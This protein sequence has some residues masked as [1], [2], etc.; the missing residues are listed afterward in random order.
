MKLLVALAQ[1]ESLILTKDELIAKA[2]GNRPVSDEAITRA[3]SDLRRILGDSPDDPRYIKTIPRLGYRLL[4]KPIFVQAKH[5]RSGFSLRLV[6]AVLLITMGMWYLLNGDAPVLGELEFSSEAFEVSLPHVREFDFSSDGNYMAYITLTGGNQVLRVK[7]IYTRSSYTLFSHAGE[8]RAPRF[9]PADGFLAVLATQPRCEIHVLDLESIQSIRVIPCNDAYAA[10]PDWQTEQTLVFTDRTAEGGWDVIQ[11]EP[12]AA[13]V[14]L[15]LPNS[16]CVQI[17]QL[18]YLNDDRISFVCDMRR[19]QSLQRWPIGSAD[20]DTL[21]TLRDIGF[22]DWLSIDEVLVAHRSPWKP[23]LTYLNVDTGYKAYGEDHRIDRFGVTGP[24]SVQTLRIADRFNTWS[25]SQTGN[26]FPRPVSIVD[27]SIRSVSASSDGLLFIS[28]RDEISNVWLQEENGKAVPLIQNLDK[29]AVAIHSSE[30]G[31]HVAVTFALADDGQ[32]STIYSLQ[33]QD[34]VP[35][36]YL[37]SASAPVRFAG[38]FSVFVPASADQQNGWY[39]LNIDSGDSRLVTAKACTD[40]QQ[41]PRSETLYCALQGDSNDRLVALAADDSEAELIPHMC[42]SSWVV[43]S[44][45]IWYIAPLSATSD[46]LYRYHFNDLNNRLML[47]IPVSDSCSV[48][49]LSATADGGTVY[50]TVNSREQLD[51]A[52]LQIVLPAAGM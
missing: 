21:M 38:D 39:E 51:L 2:W 19:G 14:R 12:E 22:Y 16:D 35:V 42:R 33:Q 20:I 40:V 4:Q 30:S 17:S 10:A 43:D 3:V 32:E 41:Q 50:Y 26:S 44:H 23:G 31:R 13:P 11:V 9:S 34:L 48:S 36:R 15:G 18:R 29:P 47:Q 1:A 5:H 8:L 28:S 7:E 49:D 37:S 52:R 24:Y 46:A 45:G 6:S 25:V 27:H